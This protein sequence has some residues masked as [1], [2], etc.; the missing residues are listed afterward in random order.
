MPHQLKTTYLHEHRNTERYK[1]HD[2]DL[3]LARALSSHGFE[4][5]EEKEEA[6]S[7]RRRSRICQVFQLGVAAA[8][9]VS[10]EH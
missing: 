2:P 10:S 4:T 1:K 5:F 9:Y 7:S 6:S 8:H 3:R